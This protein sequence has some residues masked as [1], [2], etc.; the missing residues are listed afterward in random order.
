MVCAGWFGMALAMSG[1]SVVGVLNDGALAQ[2]AWA[3]MHLF[4]LALVIPLVLASIATG[5][6][7]SLWTPWGLVQ[8]W[9]VLAKF[10][11]SVSI[12]AVAASWESFIV[13]ALAEE[14][15]VLSAAQ[16]HEHALQLMVCMLSF[17]VS[18]ALAT[19]LSTWK[20][21]ALTPWRRRGTR[22]A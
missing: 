8:H 3:L 12:V 16:R 5:L 17:S 1:L 6:V 20:P 15:P 10:V 13:R 14:P 2:S 11:I 19:W 22:S 9:W 21:N 18:L 4:D 7:L